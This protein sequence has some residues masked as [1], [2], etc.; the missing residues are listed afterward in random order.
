MNV[1]AIIELESSRGER[2]GLWY[3]LKICK[4][5][6]YWISVEW[7]FQ[8]T[9]PSRIFAVGKKYVCVCIYIPLSVSFKY[10]WSLSNI[11]PSNCLE[12]QLWK[13]QSNSEYWS[14]HFCNLWYLD[15]YEIHWNVQVP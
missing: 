14:P 5:R 8:R 2:I 6:F 11:V 4:V 10:F 3:V 12:D 7:E 1:A 15:A 9:E 13:S